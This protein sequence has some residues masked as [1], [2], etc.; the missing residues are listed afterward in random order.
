MILSTF[1]PYNPLFIRSQT[2]FYTYIRCPK[3]LMEFSIVDFVA[4]SNIF[5]FLHFSFRFF[6]FVFF[7][8]SKNSHHRYWATK[9]FFFWILIVQPENAVRPQFLISLPLC[10]QQK[11]PTKWIPTKNYRKKTSKLCLATN[12]IWP[13]CLQ[14]VTNSTL[15][16]LSNKNFPIFFLALDFR[17]VALVSFIYWR[18]KRTQYLERIAHRICWMRKEKQHKK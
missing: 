7:F 11:T 1:L 17:R 4:I 2:Q 6:P 9:H 13:K 16:K 12:G 18:L 15:H 14:F 10:H 8:T 5:V 3:R